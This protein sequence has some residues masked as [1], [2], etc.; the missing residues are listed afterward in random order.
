MISS[1]HGRGFWYGLIA[2]MLWGMFPVYFKLIGFVPADQIIAHRIVWS[3]LLLVMVVALGS[4]RRELVLTGPVI[5]L[6]TVAALL[7]AVPGAAGA[8]GA[9]GNPACWPTGSGGHHES[10]DSFPPTP[11]RRL[12]RVA[13]PCL[14]GI[15]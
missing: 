12:P 15:P 3:F 11:R 7:I 2:Y 4:L 14:A 13:R 6:Y 1:G 10:P 8:A 5:R 9:A